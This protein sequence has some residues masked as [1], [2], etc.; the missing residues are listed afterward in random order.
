MFNV[1]ISTAIKFTTQEDVQA[2]RQISAAA[3]PKDDCEVVCAA[4]KVGYQNIV[5]LND[6]GRLIVRYPKAQA[7]G[8]A[9]DGKP[10]VLHGDG[11]VPIDRS[12][13]TNVETQACEQTEE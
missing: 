13:L 11:F 2:Y 8:M 5:L 6:N 9:V 7:R 3:L 12:D 4:Y 1:N 10:V